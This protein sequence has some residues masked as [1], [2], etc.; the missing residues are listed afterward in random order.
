MSS[1]EASETVEPESS[2]SLETMLG[3]STETGRATA[4]TPSSSSGAQALSNPTLDSSESSR[5]ATPPVERGQPAPGPW[6]GPGPQQNGGPSGVRPGAAEESLA[7]LTSDQAAHGHASAGRLPH[8]GHSTGGLTLAPS[9]GGALGLG[10]PLAG[11]VNQTADAAALQ[12]LI[13]QMQ[14]QQEQQQQQMRQQQ[15]Q[16]QQQTEM[17]IRMLQNLGLQS[18]PTVAP[19]PHPPPLQP[20]NGRLETFFV[21]NVSAKSHMCVHFQ[22]K[23]VV[24][25]VVPGEQR[26][27]VPPQASVPPRMPRTNTALYHDG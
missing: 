11:S 25:P 19:P 18:Q 9:G 21:H 16:Q 4:L 3:F 12:M 7:A 23:A 6:P 2:G 20:Q 26:W 15:E 22:R 24:W 1:S 5:P 14:Q 13:R 27:W 8:P 17:M 10:R